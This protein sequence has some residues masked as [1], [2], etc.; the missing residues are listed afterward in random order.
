MGT[1]ALLRDPPEV[2]AR[3]CELMHQDVWVLQSSLS[4]ITDMMVSA[5][6]THERPLLVTYLD[7][8]L[9]AGFT[10]AELKGALNRNVV[11]WAVGSHGARGFLES[12]RDSARKEEVR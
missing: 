12:L 3:T 9:C 4:E 10:D 11:D 1:A 6:R 8:L 2:F 7:R 5:L